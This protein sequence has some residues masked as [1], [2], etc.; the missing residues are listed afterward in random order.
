MQEYEA[1]NF[2]R[3][4]FVLEVQEPIIGSPSS[5]PVQ[6]DNAPTINK[7]NVDIWVEFNILPDDSNQVSMG[8]K[9]R[10]RNF[11]LAIMRFCIKLNKGDQRIIQL[12]SDAK[13][14]FLS[15]TENR[16]TYRTPRFNRVGTLN[17]KTSE[18]NSWYQ[19]NVECPYYFDHI[20]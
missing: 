3:S 20:G 2:I 15:K 14:A 17:N 10:H 11:G 19:V 6:F 18:P 1:F 4:K 7:A 5:I 12:A 9:N 8:R 16:I 13:E